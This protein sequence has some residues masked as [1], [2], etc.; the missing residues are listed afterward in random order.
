M[1][2][3]VKQDVLQNVRRAFFWNFYLTNRDFLKLEWIWN[4][5]LRIFICKKIRWMNETRWIEINFKDYF[6]K[7]KFIKNILMGREIRNHNP[8]QGWQSTWSPHDCI[9]NWWIYF[10][11][12]NFIKLKKGYFITISLKNQD[13]EAPIKLRKRLFYLKKNQLLQFLQDG[14]KYQIDGHG[15]K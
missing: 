13:A 9:K 5:I 8:G 11:R 2:I 7:G 15:C 1:L 6:C 3:I 14:I 4:G 12:H 10:I